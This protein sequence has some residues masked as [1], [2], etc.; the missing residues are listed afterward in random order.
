MDPA[1]Y[2]WGLALGVSTV[3]GLF[4]R[5]GIVLVIFVVIFTVSVAGL[6]AAALCSAETLV[7]VFG[8]TAM[9]TPVIGAIAFVGTLLG[10]SVRG[11][12]TKT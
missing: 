6:L 8:M 1:Y 10:S 9:A 5:P 12:L 7:W 11:V 3:L 2:I 4:I